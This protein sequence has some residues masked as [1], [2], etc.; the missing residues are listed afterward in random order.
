MAEQKAWDQKTQP[1]Q[2]EARK[3]TSEQLE[4]FLAER[5]DAARSVP[6]PLAA[7]S[8]PVSPPGRTTEG[9]GGYGRR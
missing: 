9:D 6:N 4:K 1:E 5:N 2:D 7:P 8:A 3:R